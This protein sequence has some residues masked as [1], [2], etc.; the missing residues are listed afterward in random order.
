MNT[1]AE[2]SDFDRT[3]GGA[4]SL[5]DAR[6]DV[7]LWL[8][9]RGADGDSSRRAVLILSELASNAVE[10]SPDTAY[11]VHVATLDRS[12]LDIAVRNS[13]RAGSTAPPESSALAGPLEPR[14]RGLAIVESLSHGISVLVTDDEIRVSVTCRTV[15]RP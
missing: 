11:H 2:G 1:P 3:Y 15:T 13:R 6:S 7:R 9:G 12:T 4:G 8:D 5:S 10:A 14:G